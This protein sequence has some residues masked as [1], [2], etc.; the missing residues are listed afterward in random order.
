MRAHLKSTFFIVS[1]TVC[2]LLALLTP[3]LVFVLSRSQNSVEDHYAELYVKRQ[4]EYATQE[5]YKQQSSQEY[6][7]D[8]YW[9]DDFVYRKKYNDEA[10]N[11]SYLWGCAYKG[12]Q[13]QQMTTDDD[14]VPMWWV[15]DKHG[16]ALFAFQVAL[17][18]L[19][20][21]VFCMAGGITLHGIIMVLHEP[22]NVRNMT[23]ILAASGGF[24]IL[25]ILM[26][27]FVP[28]TVAFE[29][30]DLQENGWYGQV[31]ILLIMTCF[32][33]IIFSFS[34]AVIVRNQTARVS[35]LCFTPFDEEG[36]SDGYMIHD[37]PNIGTK[38]IVLKKVD[39]GEIQVT[40][41][42]EESVPE[43]AQTISFS[44]SKKDRIRSNGLPKKFSIKSLIN[45]SPRT[46]TMETEL[47]C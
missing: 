31:G 14:F 32:F 3:L 6:A 37:D 5:M 43:A 40:E 30:I 23:S 35:K 15:G 25:L 46:R 7:H 10:E 42:D 33:W 20:V 28:G 2:S 41:E 17:T 19:Y 12:K 21:F 44:P 8:D 26:V 34:F 38:K 18:V 29:G 39:E 9:T 11:C 27:I 24:C 47:S 4:K 16:E 36:N 13:V 22:E 45:K 1:W